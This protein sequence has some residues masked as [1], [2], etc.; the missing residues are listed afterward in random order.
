MAISLEKFAQHLAD[1]SLLSAQQ[2][3]AL[4][5]SLRPRDSM[6]FAK[7]LVKQNALTKYQAEQILSGKANS[8]VLGNYVILEKLGQGG[9]GMVL[10]AKHRRMDRTVA[11]LST[12]TRRWSRH[13]REVLLGKQD[14]PKSAT[15]PHRHT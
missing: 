6:Q 12:A 10:K 11:V 13:G 7:A 3:A 8:L 1:S 2:V 15:A 4:L 9:I 14:L 5:Q